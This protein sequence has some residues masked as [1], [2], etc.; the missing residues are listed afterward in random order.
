ML[1][2]K[3][4]KHHLPMLERFAPD[5]RFPEGDD[6]V[7]R[8]THRLG[9]KAGRV[10]CAGSIT[11]SSQP[12]AS[13]P[14]KTAS[15]RSLAS[16]TCDSCGRL[17]S[18]GIMSRANSSGRAIWIAPPRPQSRAVTSMRSIWS[19]N[20]LMS[21]SSWSAAR[22]IS[23]LASSTWAGRSTISQAAAA[24]IGKEKTMMPMSGTK[25][26]AQTRNICTSPRRVASPTG[27]ETRKVTSARGASRKTRLSC[28][29]VPHPSTTRRI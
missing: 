12:L 7:Q 27:I 1:A 3:R 5:T 4:Q 23:T 10:S 20:P 28:C 22:P 25:E 18:R 2:V 9:T 29:V 6:P 15:P 8:M 16:S 24:K 21:P 13:R 26:F 11:R 19:V 14:K 17:L